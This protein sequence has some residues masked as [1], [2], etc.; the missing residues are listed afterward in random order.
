MI[1]PE[2]AK[3]LAGK[4]ALVTGSASGI[5]LARWR[6]PAR[7]YP[8]AAFDANRAALPDMKAPNWRRIINID[9]PRVA[10]A[11]EAACGPAPRPPESRPI[12]D[13]FRTPPGLRRA[14]VPGPVASN[15]RPIVIMKG[16][17]Y[18]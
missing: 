8:S 9:V 4:V 16:D 7:I 3:S 10:A 1:D 17:L 18:V 2:E 5:G 13:V 14:S 6:A 11:T 12:L 15:A